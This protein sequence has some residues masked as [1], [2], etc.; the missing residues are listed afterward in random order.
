MRIASIF[1][2]PEPDEKNFMKAQNDKLVEIYNAIVARKPDKK[3][4][5]GAVLLRAAISS[6][7]EAQRTS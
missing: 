5:Y 7:D 6:F 1:R 3:Y 2:S 4:I